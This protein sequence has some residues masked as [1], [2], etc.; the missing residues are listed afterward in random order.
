[1]KP[2]EER[3]SKLAAERRESLEQADICPVD[4]GHALLEP[5]APGLQGKTMPDSDN[6]VWKG[7]VRARGPGRGLSLCESLK[8]L[9]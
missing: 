3:P 1:M 5:E 7:T 8:M 9:P 4:T 2:Q 6:A